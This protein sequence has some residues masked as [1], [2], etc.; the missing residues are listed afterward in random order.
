MIVTPVEHPWPEWIRSGAWRESFDSSMPMLPALAHETI[1]VA[2]DHD[3]TIARL[4]HVVSKDPML[5]TRVVQMANAAYCAPLQTV[6]TLSDA[7]VRMGTSAVRNMVIAV[8][9]A[10]RGGD[11]RIYGPGGRA[12][13]DHAIGTAYM[14]H[15]VAEQVGWNQDE[16]F[17]A[18]LLHDVGKLLLLKLAYDWARQ[19]GTKVPSE[20]IEEVMAAEH[21]ATGAVLMRSLHLP[22]QLIEGVMWHHEPQ[23]APHHSREAEVIYVADRLSHRYGFGCVRDDTPLLDDAMCGRVAPTDAWLQSIDNRAVGLYTVARR[24]LN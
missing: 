12:Q 22:L 2:V 7:I 16:A 21:A 5:A 19:H 1:A 11:A 3:V 13:I 24:I 14:A 10:S 9:L 23:A 4:S 20:Q 18:G 17:L 15:I 6:A 8:C